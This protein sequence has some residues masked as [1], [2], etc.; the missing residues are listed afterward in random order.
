MKDYE[1]PEINE[2]VPGMDFIIGG[3]SIASE[4]P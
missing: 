1:L 3:G 2:E 4:D